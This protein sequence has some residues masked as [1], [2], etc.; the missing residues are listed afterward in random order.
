GEDVARAGVDIFKQ[1]DLG[2]RSLVQEW[3][4]MPV[5]WRSSRA[6][7]TEAIWPVWRSGRHDPFRGE[8]Q[9]KR[10]ALADF[11]GDQQF[12]IVPDGDVFGDGQAQPCAAGGAR[13][14]AVDPVEAL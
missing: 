14:A 9:G 2:H 6:Q 12:G 8:M 10:A 5:L 3:K 11:A 7:R 4:V 1:D 13:A